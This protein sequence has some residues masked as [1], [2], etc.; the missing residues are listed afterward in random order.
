MSNRES[1]YGFPLSK[2]SK[3]ARSII[4]FSIKSANYYLTKNLHNYCKFITIKYLRTLFISF[5]LAEASIFRHSD[6]FEN[7]AFA[8]LTAT[9]TSS[10]TNYKVIISNFLHLILLINS[11]NNYLI[12]FGNFNYS[13]IISWI[14]CWKRIFSYRV[15]KFIVDEQLKICLS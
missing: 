13:F 5:P 15:H 10:F 12:S 6:S 3:F 14:N 8:A 11:I 4:L 1:S 2:L 9:S 7:A